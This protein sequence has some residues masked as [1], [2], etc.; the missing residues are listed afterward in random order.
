MTHNAAVQ[1]QIRA[2]R[3]F[4]G[5]NCLLA[6]IPATFP[7]IA[8]S[9]MLR[10]SFFTAVDDLTGSRVRNVLPIPVFQPINEA[11]KPHFNAG[12]ALNTGLAYS[13]SNGFLVS[14]PSSLE[15][16][17]GGRG[18][19]GVELHLY[20][21]ALASALWARLSVH[22]LC[23][24]ALIQCGSALAAMYSAHPVVRHCGSFCG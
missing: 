23:V 13:L 11:L 19:S 10:E 8:V 15:R 1:P 24:R 3:E 18:G 4:V 2:Q 9:L 14:W 7:C 17:T 21:S 16:E 5:W 12:R 6:A 22:R 20:V